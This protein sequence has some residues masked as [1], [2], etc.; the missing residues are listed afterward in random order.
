M[1]I[2]KLRGWDADLKKLLPPID[3]SG[4]LSSYDW[5]GKKDVPIMRFVGLQD[6]LG[7]DIYEDYI[8]VKKAK[9][10]GN[11]HDGVKLPLKVVY[12]QYRF[13]LMNRFG[14][15]FG[16]G[17]IAYNPKAFQIIGNIHQNP[18]LL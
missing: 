18:E 11:E 14:S 13:K 3:L 8:L 4:P 10:S 9:L 2:I 5:L 7:Q 15:T 17:V 1:N 16:L 6:M 12:L